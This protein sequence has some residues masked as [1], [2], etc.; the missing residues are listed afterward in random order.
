L[1]K[2]QKGKR[3]AKASKLYTK[4]FNPPERYFDLSPYLCHGDTTTINP[5]GELCQGNWALC[6]L[7]IRPLIPRVGPPSAECIVKAEA[8]ARVFHVGGKLIAYLGRNELSNQ[9]TFEYAESAE[10]VDLVTDC[11]GRKH[12]PNDKPGDARERFEVAAAL[13]RSRWASHNKADARQLA[14]KLGGWYLKIRRWSWHVEG[15]LLA[16][17]ERYT[18]PQKS[19]KKSRGGRSAA[20]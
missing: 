10:R 6:V 20:R 13:A 7:L 14:A 5:D 8:F 11:S 16:E 17:R 12:R 3:K 15:R 19:Q 1:K 2:R 18:A 4:T 9:P